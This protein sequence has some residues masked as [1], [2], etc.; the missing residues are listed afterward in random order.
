M[1][2]PNLFNGSLK[3]FLMGARLVGY[4][5]QAGLVAFHECQEW[6]EKF[7]ASIRNKRT[8]YQRGLKA[9]TQIEQAL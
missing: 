1:P 9:L 8:F 4:F 2:L 7:I 5:C 6:V 3:A